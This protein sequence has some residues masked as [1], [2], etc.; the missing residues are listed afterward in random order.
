MSTRPEASVVVATFDRAAA[1]R[2]LL[3]A[4]SRQEGAAPFE[5]VVGIDGSTDGTE[6]LLAAYAAPFTLRWESAANAGRASALNRALRQATGRLVIILDDD[7][8]PSPGL[9]AAHLAEHAPGE[10]PRF[11][12]GAAPI[13]PLPGQT[14]FRRYMAVTRNEHYER[15]AEPGRELHVRDLYSGNASVPR[16]V[17]LEVGG[18][19]ER[20]RRYGGEDVDLALRLEA[21]GVRFGFSTRAWATEGYDK[22]YP[23]LARDMEGEGANAVALALEHPRAAAG[24]QFAEPWP[25]P[26]WWKAARRALV[27]ATELVPATRRLVD[28]V[29]GA[30]IRRGTRRTHLLIRFALEY[31]YWLGAKPALEAARA[32][33][34]LLP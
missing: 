26:R 14:P 6:A 3:D 17:L 18:F 11:V 13:E 19:D 15:L 32:E 25:Q 12:M 2:R 8:V 29:V 23:E 16:D 28:G 22:T 10:G 5:V 4:L 9:V 1:V 24:Q 20:F 7:M 31:H 21:A 33:G 34:R 30:A 27:A